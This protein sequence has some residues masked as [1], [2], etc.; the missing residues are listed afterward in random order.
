MAHVKARATTAIATRRNNRRRSGIGSKKGREDNVGIH[1]GLGEGVERRGPARRVLAPEVRD[2][3]TRLHE[4][5][6]P[7]FP[8]ALT[9]EITAGKVLRDHEVRRIHTTHRCPVLDPRARLTRAG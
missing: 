2:A 7:V 5:Q 9:E 4:Y 3:L 6:P 1:H 8:E